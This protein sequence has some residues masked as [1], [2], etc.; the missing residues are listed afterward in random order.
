MYTN[1]RGEELDKILVNYI[2]LSNS[3]VV[4]NYYV[5]TLF[6]FPLVRFRGRRIEGRRNNRHLDINNNGRTSILTKQL[7]SQLNRT[8]QFKGYLPLCNLYVPRYLHAKENTEAEAAIMNVE[9]CSSIV[10]FRFGSDLD[11]FPRFP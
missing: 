2:K 11:S 5:H 6:Q 3:L 7:L 1:T 4:L 9:K 10:V 8:V